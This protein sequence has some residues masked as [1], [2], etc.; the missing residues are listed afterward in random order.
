MK[1]I[2]CYIVHDEI[3][4]THHF[5]WFESM[6]TAMIFSHFLLTRR[7]AGSLWGVRVLG[8]VPHDPGRIFSP[9][10]QPEGGLVVGCNGK[11]VGILH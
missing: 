7:I 1:I 6:K 3:I 4:S 8:Q 11:H 2:V 5:E 9:D 10:V